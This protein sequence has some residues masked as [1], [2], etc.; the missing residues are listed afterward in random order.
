[1]FNANDLIIN[2]N[3]NTHAR[4]IQ[5]NFDMWKSAPSSSVYRNKILKS[6]AVSVL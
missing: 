6:S 3:L 4:K 5:L 1:M 2:N